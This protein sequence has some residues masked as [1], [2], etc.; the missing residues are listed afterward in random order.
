MIKKHILKILVFITNLS[1]AVSGIL[2]IKNQA[3][4][5]TA[6]NT[7]EN[8]E[9]VPLSQDI[10]DAQDKISADREQKLRDLNISPKETRKVDVGTTTTTTTTTKNPVSSSS[11]SK[12]STKTKTS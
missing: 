9:I 1:L 6:L 11:S 8:A 2:F 3:D 12:S 10:M 7:K 4:K 5:K